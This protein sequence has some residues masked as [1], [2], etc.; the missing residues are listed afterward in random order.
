MRVSKYPIFTSKNVFSNIESTSYKLMLRS[1]MIRKSSKGIYIW[2]PIGV[3]VLNK[4]VNLI[5]RYMNSIGAIE[6]IMPVMQ[7]EYLWK[8]SGRLKINN[9]E[10]MSIIDRKQEKYILGPTN[11]EVILNL[12]NNEIHSCKDLPIIFYQI[13]YKFRDEIRPC[14][15]VIRSREFIMKDAYSFHSSKFSLQKTYNKIFHLYKKIFNC[16]KV[17]FSV[18]QADTGFIGG[19]I[20]HEFYARKTNNYSE[21][22]NYKEL[23]LVKISNIHSIEE[24]SN[25]LNISIKKIVKVI[26]IRNNNLLQYNSSLLALVIRADKELNFFYVSKILNLKLPIELATENDIKNILKINNSIIGVLNLSVPIIIDYDV[27]N[28]KNFVTSNNI[29]EEYLINVNW[30]KDLPLPEIKNLY[31]DKSISFT[32]K[33]KNNA[34]E[35]AHIFQLG[36]KYSHPMKAYVKK[37]DNKTELI[38]GCYGIGVTRLIAAIIEQNNDQYGIKWPPIIAPFNVALLP[39]NFCSSIEVKNKTEYIYKKLLYYNIDTLLY[40]RKEYFGVMLHNIELIGIPNILIISESNLNKGIIEYK[41]RI[42]N[43]VTLVNSNNII[44]FLLK[45]INDLI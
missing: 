10:I 35:I 12:V 34:I 41:D 20:S 6:L 39:I 25:K 24:L 40:D 13:Q 37:V 9:S 19:D 30:G 31:D 45:K 1:G 23:K 43:T 2:L 16:M 8:K 32:S 27:A 33:T 4:V 17:N 18:I 15:G 38:M 21:I 22:K 29:F 11:E 14:F 26:I 42:N 3:R 28:M 7:P 44:Q 36:T 5:K